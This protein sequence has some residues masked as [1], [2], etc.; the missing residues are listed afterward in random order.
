M[1]AGHGP[2]VPPFFGGAL[3]YVSYNAVE[4]FHEIAND[5]KDPL[6]MPEIFFVFV[7]T[8]VAFDNLKHTIKVID[9]VQVDERTN[10]RRA[11]DAV[12][13]A[14]PQSH[15]ES[16]KKAA[17][18]RAK[19]SQPKQRQPKISLQFDR[20]KVLTTPSTKAKEYIKA[21]DIIQVVLSQRLETETTTAI[22]LK[23]IARC[24]SSIRHPTCFIWSW[25]IFGSSAPRRKRWFGSP[26]IPSSCVPSPERAAAAPRP[27]K[28]AS[29]KPICSPTPKSGPSTSCWSTSAATTSAG[30]PRSAAS[31]STS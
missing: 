3:G 27:K 7:Q 30:S 18:H 15:L 24:V 17:W 19:G 13:Q 29:S 6:G 8:L 20:A 12:G 21:G 11:Y 14:N 28:S 22:R 5:K 9:N 23:S 26:A 10:L 25:R 16:A 1:P 2:G 4:Q 31:K